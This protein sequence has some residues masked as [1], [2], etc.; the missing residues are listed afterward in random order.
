MT[1]MTTGLFIVPLV[2]S[3]FFLFYKRFEMYFEKEFLITRFLRSCDPMVVGAFVFLKRFLNS[4]KQKTVLFLLN[5][6]VYPI[7]RAV[8]RSRFRI[9]AFYFHF[10]EKLR[11]RHLSRYKKQT[12]FY[13]KKV[14]SDKK[15]EYLSYGSE[16][17][18]DLE[19]EEE[20]SS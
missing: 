15:R 8:R 14:S 2:L 16:Q 9:S 4:Y 19:E 10:L 18:S 1:W 11:E 3:V 17:E 20:K 5:R 6:A 7:Q 13:L 12:S